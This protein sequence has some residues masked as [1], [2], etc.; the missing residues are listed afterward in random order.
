MTKSKK[1]SKRVKNLTSER[2]RVEQNKLIH[3]HLIFDIFS[4]LERN[5]SKREIVG[6]NPTVGKR[7]LDCFRVANS[8]NQPIQMKS[9][10]TYT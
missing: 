10:V 8:S 3:I 1:T 4:R 2:L 6:S 7:V 5:S 9:T